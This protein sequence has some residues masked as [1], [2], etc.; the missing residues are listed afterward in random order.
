MK[1]GTDKNYRSSKVSLR[2]SASKMNAIR[3]C[4]LLLLLLITGCEATYT[5]RGCTGGWFEFTCKNPGTNEIYKSKEAI[6]PEMWEKP[7]RVSLNHDERNKTLRLTVK[8]LEQRKDS[9]WYWCKRNFSSIVNLNLS[10]ERDC[11]GAFIQT[12]YRTAKTTIT[13][14][15]KMKN[16]DDTSVVFFCK[17][18]GSMCDEVLSTKSS[19]SNGIFTLKETTSNFSMSISDVSSQ[20]AG[21]YWCGVKSSDGSYRATLRKIQLKVNASITN[22]TR[23]PTVGKDFE[24]W[25]QYHNK[26]QKKQ[27]FICKG[28]D[29]SICEPLVSMSKPD[30]NPQK[31]SIK[32]TKEKKINIIVKKV[33][34]EDAGTYWC[35]A[36]NNAKSR[37]NTFFHKLQMTVEPP[38][39]PTFPATSTQATTAPAGRQAGGPQ[40]VITGIVCVTVLLLLF[41]LILI[42][43]FKRHS[44]N[45]RNAAA[46][47]QHIKEDY[48]YEEIQERPQTSDPGHAINS[49]YVTANLPQNPSASPHYSTISFQNCSG[50]E[51]LIT[52]PSSAACEYSTVTYSQSPTCSSVNQP[53]SD[54]P[55]YSTVCKP[56]EQ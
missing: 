1:R 45:K 12:A 31:F 10:V 15:Y 54:D 30:M 46:T 55:L 48:I 40:I 39:T 18:N 5:V 38:T 11:Q 19:Q 37:S 28:K 4:L 56:R 34:R 42:L 21:V 49:I 22:F 23:S 14:D 47:A 33:T 20:H 51:A 16:K 7:S 25:C 43:I 2:I 6:N 50:G 13:C 24:Y 9:G 8:K 26:S 17:E 35:G 53:S 36:Q 52:R 41:V 29:P 27:I 44:K 32:E 3:S